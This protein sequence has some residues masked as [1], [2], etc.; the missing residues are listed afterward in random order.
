MSITRRGT[1]WAAEGGVLAALAFLYFVDLFL[2]WSQSCLTPIITPFQPGS[3]RI[4]PGAFHTSAVF[5]SGQTYGWGG[6][7][8]AAG[9]LVALLVLWEATRVARLGVGLG[10]GYRS[11]ISAALAF[12]VLIFTVVNVAARLTWMS[13]TTGSLVYGGAFLWISLALAIL[14]GL[15]G[16]AHWLLW[17]EHAPRQGGAAEPPA[18]GV[19]VTIPPETPPP[20][21][22]GVCPSCGRANPEDS[23]FCSACGK[24]LPEPS[25]RR[26]G[27]RRPPPPA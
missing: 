27:G 14:I 25:T 8:T 13:S 23:R 20:P 18:A 17:Q 12:A 24:S 1:R 3:P 10:F 26:R 15:G 11:L 5:C 2:P 16:V 19:P 7:G 6:A 9:V 21:P 22:P 4:S